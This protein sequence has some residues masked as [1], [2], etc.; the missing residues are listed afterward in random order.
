[1]PPTGVVEGMD[2]VA[3]VMARLMVGG[4]DRGVRPF[5]VLLS[6]SGRMCEGVTSRSVPIV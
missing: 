1:M 2:R 6:T 5:I 3:I 4:D